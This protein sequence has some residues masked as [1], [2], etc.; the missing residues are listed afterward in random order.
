M[1]WSKFTGPTLVLIW[2]IYY[3]AKRCTGG[4]VDLADTLVCG[5]VALIAIVLVVKRGIDVWKEKKSGH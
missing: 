3:Y 2:T 4:L 5:S 1:V